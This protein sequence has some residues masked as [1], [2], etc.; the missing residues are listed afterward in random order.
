MLVTAP[1]AGPIA[2][3][4]LVKKKLEGVNFELENSCVSNKI[5]NIVLDSISNIVK[6]KN[7]KY[8]II[9]AVY[10]KMYSILGNRNS[11]KIY[12]IRKGT[13]ADINA[14]LY[15]KYTNKEVINT[16]PKTAVEMAEKGNLAIVGIETKQGDS[17]EDEF[18]KL[19]IKAPSCIIYSE[20]DNNEEFL[21]EYKRGV[22]LINTKP[23]DAAIVISSSTNY[24]SL[25]V[26]QKIISHYNHQLTTSK[27]DI[28]KSIK[29]YS[30]IIP[31]I[32]DLRF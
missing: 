32:L 4:V 15:A 5:G 7:N 16:D 20:I 26:M 8:R 9:G 6:I 18:E 21:N 29:I 17:L 2:F 23:E 1:F 19:G 25:D 13:L 22:E 14:R 3:P 31:E 12:T 28:S 27:N 10:I 24:Y 11:N 30:E